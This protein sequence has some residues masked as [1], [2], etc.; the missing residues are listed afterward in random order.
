[1]R[2][3]RHPGEFGPVSRTER[4]GS[5][6]EAKKTGEWDGSQGCRK[7]R[8]EHMQKEFKSDQSRKERASLRAGPCSMWVHGFPWTRLI[9]LLVEMDKK[10]AAPR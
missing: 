4:A 8:P 2:I 10:G 7:K 5:T 3:G 6:G 1:M 9:G